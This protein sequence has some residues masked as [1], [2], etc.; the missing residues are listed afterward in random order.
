[1]AT[2]TDSA[3]DS[4]TD[5]GHPSV[6]QYVEVGIIL[7]VLTAIE[8]G[9]Y[10]A[11]QGGVPSSV[12]IPAILFLTVMKFI[13]VIFWF[14]HLRFDNK[15]F[16]RL[17]VAGLVLAGAVYGIVALIMFNQPIVTQV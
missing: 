5:H 15:L 3:H 16:T 8:I 1:M 17:F 9:L 14:M 6:G 4:D 10:Y 11:G 2:Q 13:L 7:A 12:T